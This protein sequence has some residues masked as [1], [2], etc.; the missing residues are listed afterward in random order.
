MKKKKVN[1]KKMYFRIGA[2]ICFS[3][4]LIL[5][6]NLIFNKENEELEAVVGTWQIGF[7]YYADEDTTEGKEV[8]EVKQELHLVKDGTFYT[9]QIN[10][11]GNL[12]DSSVSGTYEVYGNDVVL[13]YE[14]MGKKN[15]I[16]LYLKESENQL[17][18]NK[19]CSTFYKTG[20]L[21]SYFVI[22]NYKE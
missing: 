15:N 6:L 2:T 8:A 4:A 16:T 19:S 11:K 14:Q 5:I 9:K 21:N 13:S 10:V 12:S 1:N 3:I 20:D 7:K 22:T 18:M 17:C